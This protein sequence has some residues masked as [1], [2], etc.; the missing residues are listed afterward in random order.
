MHHIS[1]HLDQMELL[2][3]TVDLPGVLCFDQQ[4]I[5]FP[6]NILIRPFHDTVKNP[7]ILRF[8]SEPLIVCLPL[9]GKYLQLGSG[10][11][12]CLESNLSAL[13]CI[14]IH[15]CS[16]KTR[17][18]ERYLSSKAQD[19]CASHDHNS[20]NCFSRLCSVIH[21]DCSFPVPSQSDGF[22]FVCTGFRCSARSEP[23]PVSSLS[24]PSLPFS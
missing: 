15:G 17:Y 3:H 7:V 12:Q 4:V 13:L 22:C 5:D 10:L 16:R 8:R 2:D 23:V 24:H 11:K 14:R 19:K 6:L 21:T 1:F 9:Q 20:G 18:A